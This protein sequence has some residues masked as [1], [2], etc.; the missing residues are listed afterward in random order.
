MSAVHELLQLFLNDVSRPA[1]S[2]SQPA[3]QPASHAKL[4]ISCPQ[5][6]SAAELTAILFKGLEQVLS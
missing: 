5:P 6:L 4:P 1:G 3:S 2:G